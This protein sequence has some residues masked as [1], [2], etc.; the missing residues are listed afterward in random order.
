MPECG[1][2]KLPD[3]LRQ[4]ILGHLVPLSERED[5]VLPDGKKEADLVAMDLESMVKYVCELLRNKDFQAKLPL[6]IELISKRD[7]QREEFISNLR[8]SVADAT[9]AEGILL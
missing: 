2:C 8:E 6:I 3:C 5:I 9:F 1:K 4:Y 7:V